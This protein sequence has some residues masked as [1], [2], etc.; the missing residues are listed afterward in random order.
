MFKWCIKVKI[1]K[2]ADICFSLDTDD[3]IVGIVGALSKEPL[4][5]TTREVLE[6]T[7]SVQSTVTVCSSF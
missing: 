7:I 6:S 2:N 5:V 3:I 1:D 4:N